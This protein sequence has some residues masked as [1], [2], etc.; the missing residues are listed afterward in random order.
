VA[1]LRIRD[2]ALEIDIDKTMAGDSQPE[3]ERIRRRRLA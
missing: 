1:T 3:L 2:R